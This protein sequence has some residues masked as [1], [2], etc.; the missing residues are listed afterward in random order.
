MKLNKTEKVIGIIIAVLLLFVTLSSTF[1]FLGKLKVSV[2]DWISFNACAPVSFLYLCFFIVF[3]INK[4]AT[5]LVLTAL[6]TYFLGTMAM[7]V[8]PWNGSYLIA[9][10]GHII[11]TM[12]LIWVFYVVIR[13][14]NYKALAIELL[15]GMLIFVPYIAYVQTFNQAHAEEISRILQQQ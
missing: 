7:F 8:L 13:H 10:V 11:M 14:K 3:L 1:F 2:L 6:P 5:G 4:K 9:H 15:V 12:N